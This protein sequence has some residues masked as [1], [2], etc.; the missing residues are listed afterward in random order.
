VEVEDTG[1]VVVLSREDG[2]VD[3]RRVHIGNCVLMSVPSAE[4][5]IQAAHESD[6]AVNETQFLVVSPV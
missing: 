3:V 2:F 1:V 4:A 6:L 5:Q